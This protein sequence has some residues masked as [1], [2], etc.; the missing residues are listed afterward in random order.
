[1]NCV[2]FRTGKSL[3]SRLRHWLTE[4]QLEVLFVPVVRGHDWSECIL[5]D[6]GLCGAPVRSDG[7]E[8]GGCVLSRGEDTAASLPAQ[9]SWPLLPLCQLVV[10]MNLEDNFRVK[11]VSTRGEENETNENINHAADTGGLTAGRSQPDS[12]YGHEAEVERLEERPGHQLGQ[13]GCAAGDVAD[14]Q[15]QEDQGGGDNVRLA[16]GLRASGRG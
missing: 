8:A 14:Q 11:Y 9:A 4:S 12:Q 10:Q 15:Q 3:V 7:G 6:A 13:H 16:G 1:M 2:T 5:D